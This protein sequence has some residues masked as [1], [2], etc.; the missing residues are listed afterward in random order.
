MN[1]AEIDEY[2]DAVLSVELCLA[3]AKRYKEPIDER[4]RACS[5]TVSKRAI[6]QRVKNL[7]MGI[8]LEEMPAVTFLML[9]SQVFD[10]GLN[11]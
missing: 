3:F 10:S 11:Q 8:A 1:A 5:L 4:V 2:L 7:F 9:Q 6:H